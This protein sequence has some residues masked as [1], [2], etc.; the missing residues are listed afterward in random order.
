M[1]RP[2]KEVAVAIEEQDAKA[3][4]TLPGVGEATAERIIAKLRRKVSKFALMVS[5]KTEGGAV[6]HCDVVEEAHSALVSV[7]HSSAEARKLLDSALAS[8]KKFKDAGALIEQ[9]YL[10]QNAS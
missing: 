7:G 9:V 8:G 10:L 3:L 2:I 5:P 6:P 4:A 1:V